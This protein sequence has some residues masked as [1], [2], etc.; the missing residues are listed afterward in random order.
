LSLDPAT[1]T[2][3]GYPLLLQSGEA[4]HGQPLHDRQHPHD[5]FMELG[6]LYQ[7]EINK[8][9]AWS[10]Y[11]APS[12]EPALGPVAFMHR[13]SGMDNP[14]APLSHHWQDATHV[15]FGVITA[16]LLTRREPMEFRS[17]QTGFLFWTHHAQS[18]SEL[19]C[20]RW[21]WLSQITGGI[22]SR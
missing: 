11:A 5:F 19:E 8:Q 22:T 12:G 3:R 4:Y 14:T 16:G 6:A 15:S 18:K 17:C 10:I 20:C 13:P 9:V 1:V 21:C 7:R 2:P